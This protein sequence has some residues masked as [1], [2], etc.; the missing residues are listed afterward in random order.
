MNTEKRRE[1][2]RKAAAKW[3]SKN[4]KSSTSYAKGTGY[5]AQK[6]WNKVH[7]DKLREYARR[8]YWKDP[9][10]RRARRRELNKLARLS[11]PEK[12]RTEKR[13]YHRAM[14]E[15]KVGRPRPNMCELCMG[16]FRKQP[17]ADHD[18]KTGIYRG[19]ICNRCNSVLGMVRDDTSLLKSM[20]A[21]II[22]HGK[23]KTR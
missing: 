18:H 23:R 3:R 17:H 4:P 21:W 19:W 9:D 14:M 13:D 10:K 6:E 11:N 8:W 22:N 5:A 12:V 15:K 2:C 7:P 20:M 1:Q 16:Q